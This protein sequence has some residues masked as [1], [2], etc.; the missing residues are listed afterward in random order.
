MALL[1]IVLGY[2]LGVAIQLN[3]NAKQLKKMDDA[4]ELMRG[5]RPIARLIKQ[6]KRFE[7]N[8]NKSE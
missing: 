3:K 6:V 8:K 2:I 1:G 7:R 4:F 5:E